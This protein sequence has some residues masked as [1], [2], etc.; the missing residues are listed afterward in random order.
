MQRDQRITGHT[1]DFVLPTKEVLCLR[2]SLRISSGE[3][4]L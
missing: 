1:P 2:L 4:N 3:S